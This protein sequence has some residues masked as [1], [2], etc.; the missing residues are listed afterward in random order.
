[1]SFGKFQSGFWIR[2]L[3]KVSGW[4]GC[5]NKKGIRRLLTTYYP[6]DQTSSAENAQAQIQLIV[7][8]TGVK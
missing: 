7:R 2:L 4:I 6:I 8:K 5:R 3:A 1:M